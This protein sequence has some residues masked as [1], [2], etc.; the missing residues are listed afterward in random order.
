MGHFLQNRR[1]FYG[2]YIVAA[3]FVIL[4]FN[5]GARYAFGV[6]FKPIIAEFGWSRGAVSFVF[7]V[8]MIVF[9]LGLMV[10]GKLYDRFGP[11]WVIIIST[12]F[13]SSGFIMTSFMRSMPQFFF[14]YGILAALGLAGTAV[15]LMATLTSKWFD[16]W[17]GFAISLSL[18]GNSI[19]TL[20]L[21]PFFS[22]LALSYGWRTAYLYPGIMM[23]VANI[24]LAF[25]VIK[26]DPHQLGLKPFGQEQ[27]ERERTGSGKHGLPPAG[28]GDFG[29]RQAMGTRSFWLFVVMMFVCGGGD[30]FAATHLIPLATDNGISPLTAGNMLAWYGAMSLAGI[31]VASPLADLI[32]SKTPIVL[33]FALRFFLYL[34][35]FK[36]KTVGSFYLFAFLFGFT[37]LITAPLTPMLVVKLYGG[38]HL[39]LLTGFVN[40]IHF[41]GA[42][43]WPLMAGTLF[44]RTGN[45]QLTFLIL[46][47]AAVVAVICTTCIAERRHV[48]AT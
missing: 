43:L 42:A 20:V 32:G 39:G 33:T 47:V 48:V 41:L 19:G 7:A 2:W 5:G 8:N 34:F 25:F 44:D 17:R 11:K 6:M 31:L 15:P 24:L 27:Q 22:R 21:V 40:A 45:Y 38:T 29:L 4:F 10:V 14:S 46:A 13:I 36:Y 26:G 1:L 37:H 35:L 30:Y 18:A 3:S 12:L 23:L 16:K 28:G 9:A